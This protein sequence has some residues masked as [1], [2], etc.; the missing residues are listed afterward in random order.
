M[1]CSATICENKIKSA[2]FWLKSGYL[3]KWGIIIF[4]KSL[5]SVTEYFRAFDLTSFLIVPI[6][7]KNV[8][9]SCNNKLSLRFNP[10]VKVDDTRQPVLS[11]LS[12]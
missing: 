3:L 7:P 4:V 10:I 12:L 5:I 2:P 1:F 8:C 6:P 9:K 11:F